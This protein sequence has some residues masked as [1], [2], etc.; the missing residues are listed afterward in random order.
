MI[1]NT[2]S[3]QYQQYLTGLQNLIDYYKPKF[4]LFKKLPKSKQKLWLRKDPLFRKL[5][6]VGIY[7]SSWSIDYESEVE[8]D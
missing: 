5:I 2:Q 6:K 7:V 8:N 3:A 4:I 1:I